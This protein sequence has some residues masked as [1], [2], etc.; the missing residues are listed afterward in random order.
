[1]LKNIIIKKNKNTET[2]IIEYSSDSSECG[3][4]TKDVCNEKDFDNVGDF[5][6]AYNNIVDEQHFQKQ[7]TKIKEAIEAKN[8]LY[9]KFYFNQ[10]KENQK[11]PMISKLEDS[12][13]KNKLIEY[14]EES[15]L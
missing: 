5:C 10:L 12:E 11:E 13:F 9:V 4:P 2:E 8:M 15:V 6:K 1:M 14:F 3:S 7:L